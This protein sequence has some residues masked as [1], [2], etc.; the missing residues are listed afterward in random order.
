M[1]RPFKIGLIAYFFAMPFQLAVADTRAANTNQFDWSSTP[2]WFA[3]RNE[4]GARP[5]F[6]EVC[7]TSQPKAEFVAALKKE[8]FAAAYQTI[9]NWLPGCPVSLS[10]HTLAQFALSKLAARAPSP[11]IN[12]KLALHTRWQTGLFNAIRQSGDGKTPESAFETISVEE[13]Y[14]FLASLQLKLQSQSLL[15]SPVPVDAM[16]SQS[17]NDPEAEASVVYFSPYW[18]FKRLAINLHTNEPANLHC[19]TCASD[20]TYPP[21]ANAALREILGKLSDVQRSQLGTSI[22]LSP[23]LTEQLND[24][25]ANGRLTDIQ[26][27]SPNAAA[28]HSEARLFKIW[29]S[30]TTL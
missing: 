14:N 4:Y 29:D 6:R 8:D 19:K 9:A 2:N 23:S 5:D 22:R 11:E 20:Q 7:E 10:G 27:I 21:A 1:T 18:H 28:S 24:L 30:N 16:K 25:A 12:A 26:V 17:I 3:L 15:T 13:E